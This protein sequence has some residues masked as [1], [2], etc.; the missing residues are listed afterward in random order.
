MLFE[1]TREFESGKKW[2]WVLAGVPLDITETYRPGAKEG[3]DAIRKA[4]VSIETYSPFLDV[5]IS[6]F[7]IADY[8]NLPFSQS[9]IEEA[10]D[11]IYKK[12]KELSG[13]KLG[14]LGG[15]HTLSLGVV[16]ALAEVHKELYLVVA[17]A[18]TDLRDEYEGSKVNHATWL[19]RVLDFIPP[20][21]VLLV[22]VRSGTK[23]EFTVKLLEMREDVEIEDTTMDKLIKAEAV[24]LSV[25]I[26]A[27][28]S[29]YVPGC[30][31]PEPGG[32]HYKELEEFIH[33]LGT[34]TNLIGFDLVEVAPI[35]DVS[36]I[37]SITAARLVRE[38]VA[39]SLV[40]TNV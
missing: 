26:D 29:P 10:I 19:R 18:H 11:S 6:K 31:N 33:W 30:G 20:E 4:S 8:G 38:I 5:D 17:D 7:K 35:Y 36:Q 3:P 34:S 37:T 16:K 21:R 1:G 22:G 2:D 24:Y 9:N 23:E 12:V 13:Y 27:L 28:D 15:E 32:L 25:D 39:S 40:A 14:F